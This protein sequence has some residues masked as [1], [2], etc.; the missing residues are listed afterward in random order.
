MTYTQIHEPLNIWI[1]LR[2][3]PTKILSFQQKLWGFEF[4]VSQFSEHLKTIQ[5]F[6]L[7][8]VIL[9][10]KI[11]VHYR[12]VWPLRLNTPPLT[13]FR[14]LFTLFYSTRWANPPK[15][16]I[17]HWKPTPVMSYIRRPDECAVHAL[18]VLHTSL[19]V[20]CR[21]VGFYQSSWL[22]RLWIVS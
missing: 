11:V 13:C 22:V 6:R 18:N 5:N 20:N 10:A 19:V 14:S 16:T 2:S 3:N 8:L 15:Q 1:L 21:P 9:N 7:S 12:F 17:P 4:Q